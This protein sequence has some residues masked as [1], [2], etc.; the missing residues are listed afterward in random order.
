M[1]KF[2]LILSEASKFNTEKNPHKRNTTSGQ[3]LERTRQT[4]AF[5][6]I[7]ATASRFDASMANFASEISYKNI[8]DTQKREHTHGNSQRISS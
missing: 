6:Y 7:S 1:Q 4:K 3:T 2:D 5:V 8:T